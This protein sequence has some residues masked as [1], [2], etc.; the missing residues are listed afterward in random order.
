MAHPTRRRNSVLGWLVILGIRCYQATLAN[1][2]GGR[3]RFEPTC[4]EFG[5]E[6]VRRHGAIRGGYLTVRRI[7]RCHPWGGSGHDP[8]P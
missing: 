3:C 6:A 1:F 7:L 2:I 5:I 8:V 4:S